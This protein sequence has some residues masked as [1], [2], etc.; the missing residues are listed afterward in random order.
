VPDSR[1]LVSEHV[2]LLFE[3]DQHLFAL[4]HAIIDEFAP[5]DLS[6]R[7]GSSSGAPKG[8]EELAQKSTLSN[9]HAI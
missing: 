4:P 2:R 8:Y 6:C 1:E 7:F 5:L 9:L 3:K